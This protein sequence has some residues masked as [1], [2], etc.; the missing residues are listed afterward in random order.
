ME[1]RNKTR[2][3]LFPLP[4]QGC[5]NPMLQLAKILFSKGF[6][7]T[8]IHT[9]FNAP[10]PS[11]HPLFTFLQIPDGLSE[12]Q[13][14]S[15]DVL[16]Q[17]TLLNNNCENPLRE[18]LTKLIKGSGTEEGGE[19][20]C[21]IDDSGW[22]FTQSVADS[23]NLPRFVLCAYKFTFF[24]RHLLVP[25]LRREGFLPFPDSEA[26]DSVPTFQP[27]RKKDLARIMGNKDQAEPLDAY[28]VKILDTTKPASGLIVMS[29]EELDRDSLSESHKVFTFPI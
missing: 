19:I 15:R 17:L 1:K 14:Q 18:C 29:C 27:L 2:V 13:T 21:L 5:I 12:S 16:L 24:L 3:I 22:V 25:Q 9:R 26:E 20:S 4:L 11:D 10:K 23:F 6:S 7:I 8:I 28:L